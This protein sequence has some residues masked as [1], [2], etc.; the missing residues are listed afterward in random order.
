MWLWSVKFQ[1]KLQSDGTGSRAWVQSVLSF[2]GTYFQS[3]FL[4]H[5]KQPNNRNYSCSPLPIVKRLYIENKKSSG[6]WSV[7]S[8]KKTRKGTIG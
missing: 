8:N 7:G 1:F 6:E 5:L 2:N 4:S 3:V